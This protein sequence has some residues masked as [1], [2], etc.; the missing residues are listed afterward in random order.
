VPI[1]RE[2]V[3]E[4]ARRLGVGESAE[5]LS[6][7]LEPTPEAVRPF[8]PDVPAAREMTVEGRDLRRGFLRE[9]GV[10]IPH[11]A[12]ERPP[13]D[14][15][16][17]QGNIE[18]FIGMTQIPT[19]LIGPLRING[20]HAHG[21]Y[22]VPLATSEGALAA[23]Y[24]R[25]A[26]L[27]TRAG[28]VSCLTTA[29]Q[30]QRAPGFEFAT[31]AEAGR[32]AAWVTGEFER[33]QAVAATRT[34]H[35]AL[36]DMDLHLEARTV[37]L[38]LDY[39]TGDAAGQNMVTICTE[40]VCADLLTRTP[41]T[42]RYWFIESNMS[43]DKKATSL[44]FLNT[45]GR[46]V[47]A[48]AIVP[49]ALVEKVLRT[50]PERICD[51]WRMCFIGGMQSGSIGMSG[52]IA[53]G[54]AAMFLACGQDVACVSEASVGITRFETTA[55]GDLRCGVS[56]PN[57][58]VGTVGGGTRLPTTAECLRI[59]GCEG[60]RK[61]S[62]FAEICAAVALAGELSIAGAMCSGDFSSAHEKLGRRGPP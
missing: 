13:P 48:D 8:P 34:R 59:L 62:R 45:R 28:G 61:A 35:G 12:G 42:P 52:H 23:S 2:R 46:K 29:E 41:V 9:R 25:G 10:D 31:L 38:I 39:R 5:R 16:S 27:L 26:R 3:L 51:Y 37:Y 58:I 20:L 47:L 36:L 17:L 54:L 19:A 22:Y 4:I 15:E 60:D 30:V 6:E 14:P 21:D 40:A 11:L 24:H 32:F 18:L 33:L 44:S 53:N 57:L 1:S 49:H 43:G 7:R 56:L 55:E 50:T